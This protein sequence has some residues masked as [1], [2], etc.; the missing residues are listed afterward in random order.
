[1]DKYTPEV[2]IA[3]MH[4]AKNITLILACAWTTVTLFKLSGSW[5]ALWALLMLLGLSGYKF[6]RD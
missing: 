6:V 5:H 4:M 2:V 3:A 1:M